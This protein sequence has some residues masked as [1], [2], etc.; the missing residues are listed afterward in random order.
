MK[1]I[2]NEYNKRFKYQKIE[3]DGFDVEGLWDNIEL[4]LED[5]PKRRPFFWWHNGVA[6]LL[7]LALAG[8]GIWVLSQSNST[9]QSITKS[10][11]EANQ[12]IKTAKATTLDNINEVT[13]P[14]DKVIEVVSKEHE[15][16]S[17]SSIKQSKTIT[18]KFTSARSN[19][20][21]ST[22][23]KIKNTLKSSEL[24]PSITTISSV[25]SS[26]N[27][28]SEKEVTQNITVLEQLTSKFTVPVPT[29]F[30]NEISSSV[31]SP[32]TFSNSDKHANKSEIKKNNDKNPKNIRWQVGIYGGANQLGFDFES[33]ES[34]NLASL[35]NTAESK[36]WGQSLGFNTAIIFKDQWTLNTGIEQHQ[37]WS[38]FEYKNTSNY[39]VLKE[40]VLLGVTLNAVTMD[41]ISKRFGDTLINASTYREV[42]HFNNYQQVSIPLQL[43]WQR[44]SNNW[45]YGVS[46]GVV[47]NFITKQNGKTFDATETIAAF[48]D[49]T[50]FQPLDP[51]NMSWRIS[52]LVGYT[53]ANDWTI[54]IQPGW[55][56]STQAQFEQVNLSTSL[57]QMNLNLGVSKKF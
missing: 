43:G 23:E 5:K 48:D 31:K 53:L 35:K 39:Q 20:F 52:P 19:I 55:S 51:N 36:V 25:S 12:S 14:K 44:Q 29:T 4:E 38:K 28:L 2:E 49:T 10:I 21:S 15:A 13:I 56:F 16:A 7:A 1:N 22:E 27:K 17:K 8:G 50:D 9:E 18:D 41:T 40:D 47:F 30:S 33:T 46:G 45:T 6:V 32:Q 24:A 54:S 37:L 34:T 57:Q 26:I 42:I 11:A 3:N